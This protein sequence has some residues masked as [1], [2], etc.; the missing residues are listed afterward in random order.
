LLDTAAVEHVESRTND[1]LAP[2]VPSRL[3]SSTSLRDL[4]RVVTLRR[5]MVFSIVG[6]FLVACL[7]YCLIAPRQYEARA[8][9]ALRTAPAAALSVEGAD[10]APSGS[11]ASSQ[12]QLE[13]L[14]SV[15]R[16]DQLA[17][18]VILERKLYAAPPFMGRFTAR[19]PGFNAADPKPEAESYLLERFQQRLHV[20]TMP[21]TL[22]VEIRFRCKDARLSAEV[23]N[24]L[25]RLYRQQETEL[26]KQAT[27]DSTGLLKDQLNQL[28]LRVDKDDRR[29]AQ[30]QRIHE[31]LISPQTLSDGKT[32][33]VE[34]LPELLQVDELGKE[35]AAAN[36]ERILREA[37]YR[38]ASQGDPE[39]VLAFDPRVQG[40]NGGLSTSYRQIHAHHSELELELAQIS[41]ERGPN[42]PRMQE[43]RQ[44]LGDLDRQ[45]AAE[46]ALLR[47][48]FKNAW[49]S[50][51]GH[52]RLVR[53]NLR[54]RTGEGVR[55]NEAATTYELMRKETD[56][57][58]DLYL[59]MQDKVE[60]AGLAA[61]V[62]G[63]GIWV[64]DEARPPSRPVA[65]DAPLYL[66]ITLFAG[67]WIAIGS[68]LIVESI[69]SPVAGAMVVIACL[70]STGLAGR[71]QAPTPSTSGLPTG[72]AHIPL[73]GETKSTPNARDAP[74]VWTGQ[75]GNPA[76]L[77]PP[78]SGVHG[79]AM[80]AAISAGDLLD[81][82]EFHTPEFHSTVR[83]SSTGTVKLPMVEEVRVEGMD[84]LQ[85]GKAIAESLVARGMLNHPQVSVL[86]TAFVGQDVSVLG[87]V[88]RPGVYAYTM[89]HRLYDLISAAS[90]LGP[91]AG[92]TANI[93][94]RGDPN[95]P[96]PVP[97]TQDAIEA[98]S[99]RNPELAA[100]DTVQVS[101]AGLVYVV[102]DVIRP[103]GFTADPTQEFTVLKALSLAWGP[104]QNAA[105][106]RAILI[107]EQKGGR[108]VTT[109]NLKRMLRGQDPDQPIL[110]H[111][112]L[113]VP[114][115]AVKN[116]FNRTIE[117]AIQSAAG[118]SIYA[119]LVYSQRF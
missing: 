116:L 36:S 11:F 34:H 82:S 80:A 100:G 111:D 10:S 103:G 83:V 63:S 24:L 6:G 39:V 52:E 27:M 96:H 107:R 56:S 69:R 75:G 44:Q 26:R 92:A 23:V 22:L 68:V 117:S 71:A 119:G 78:A 30:F 104:T 53:K 5:R 73:G 60:E 89:H 32:G 41:I 113:F 65:P 70:L 37:E 42:F 21:R 90:G 57:T 8:K 115:S 108:T 97:L 40:E 98:G 31:I 33:T 94:H 17:W 51:E 72:V 55:V 7:L 45:L 64:V 16:S 1:K 88:A 12:M 28:K 84:E 99:D 95:T 18:K 76:G 101:R 29:L 58:H 77:P 46:N 20:G 105:V 109:L 59:R 62:H 38:A 67:L 35:L 54:E 106:Q 118:V 85:A 93:Y 74:S 9:V 19:F 79:A 14:A 102:G 112:I 49:T 50:A 2:R 48:R 3:N 47:E 25:I 61:G 114:D 15:L 87:E 66:A 110:D 86:I 81:I 4:I 13:T 43:I 91:M